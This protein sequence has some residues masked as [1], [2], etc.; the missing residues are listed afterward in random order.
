MSR[1]LS[2]SADSQA[3]LLN[4]ITQGIEQVSAVVQNNS[5]AAEETFA[6]SEELANESAALKELLGQFE[7]RQAK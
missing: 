2:E 4:Q 1:G 6:T 3:E 7:F 5:A